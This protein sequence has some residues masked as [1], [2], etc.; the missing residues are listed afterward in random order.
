MS[1]VRYKQKSMRPRLASLGQAEAV[2]ARDCGEHG[3]RMNVAMLPVRSR[4]VVLGHVHSLFQRHPR[5]VP[6]RART[7]L[8]GDRHR[9]VTPLVVH[10]ALSTMCDNHAL[11]KAE[12]RWPR[13][14]GEH[15]DMMNVAML[16][17]RSRSVVLGA[18]HR[19]LHLHLRGM[20]QRAR[21]HPADDRQRAAA[22]LMAYLALSTVR[23]NQKRM[24]PRRAS[25]GKADTSCPREMGEYGERVNVAMLLARS[26]PVVLGPL[27]R[28]VHR[29]LRRVP[30]TARA[31]LACDR[32]RT[33]TPLSLDLALSTVWGKQKR[34]TPRLAS[35]RT[36]SR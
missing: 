35:W 10:L 19:L 26:R 36:S 3:G 8:E 28:P 7:P 21:A 11:A 33:V 32:H 29:H 27:H 4:S 22:P 1:T 30:R 17:A 14:A 20:R 15:G 9:A 5:R 24:G 18:F 25:L 16:L 23:D 6:Q 34:M 13:E 31:H 2:R 12:A